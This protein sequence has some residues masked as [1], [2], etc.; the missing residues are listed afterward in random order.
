MLTF[1]FFVVSEGTPQM[2]EIKT[3]FSDL[4]EKQAAKFAMLEELYREWNAR[5]NV[6]SRKDIDH[7]FIRHLL[8]SLSVARIIRF[9]PGT[10]IMDAG[11]GGGFP[12]IPLA[13]MFPECEFTLVDSIGKKIKV[14]EA[15]K[16]ELALDNV[17]TAN[18]RFEDH[19]GSFDFVTGRAVSD[20]K[21]FSSM[22]Y[23]KLK[24]GGM[25]SLENGILYLTGGETGQ[26]LT[27][28]RARSSTW[29]L[30]SFFTDPYFET[31]KL[32]HLSDFK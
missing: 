2:E 23:G 7:F 21:V 14:I 18:L 6:I 8:H 30:S 26:V 22:V 5:I 9:L 27:T 1:V 25:N 29:N 28:I 17:R 13:V 11:T 3:Y 4:P 16:S 15:V 20:L 19:P 32:I 24:K 31:K 12:G 10:T